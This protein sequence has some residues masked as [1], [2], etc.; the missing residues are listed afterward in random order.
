MFGLG[1]VGLAAGLIARAAGARVVGFDSSAAAVEFAA[2]LGLVECTVLD[3]EASRTDVA[4]DVLSRT[5]GAH[6]GIDAVGSAACVEMS[7]R[8]CV[9]AA[10]TCR[11]GWCRRPSGPCGCRWIG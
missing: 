4:R 11:S 9:A 10:G 5:G 7:V 1:G 2:G 3:P 8:R 6:V